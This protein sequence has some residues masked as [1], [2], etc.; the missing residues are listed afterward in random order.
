M[1]PAVS[2]MRPPLAVAGLEWL[3]PQ[4]P[5]LRGLG[6]S[7][8]DNWELSTAWSGLF[9]ATVLLVR[10]LYTRWGESN[11]TGKAIAL[12]L[13]IHMVGGLWTTTV[14]I[15][16][17]AA[18]VAK[19]E[20]IPI[21]RV[22]VESDRDR[23]PAKS[24]S[25][26]SW[27]RLP[28]SEREA[29][30]RLEK[31]LVDVPAAKLPERERSTAI[32]VA[33][34][35]PALV[36]AR[37]APTDPA[38]ARREDVKRP[39]PAGA[40]TSK[41]AEETADARAE[42][43]GSAVPGR[44]A[45]EN[46]GKP[47][48]EPSRMS[49]AP[50]ANSVAAN[51]R[52]PLVE[53]PRREDSPDAARRAGSDGGRPS[54]A[55]A[56]KPIPVAEGVGP[57]GTAAPS[58]GTA[59]GGMFSRGGP[60]RDTKRGAAGVDL[61][62]GR[63]GTVDG[64]QAPGLAVISSLPAG[65]AA[66]LPPAVREELAAVGA[67][68][69]VP[70]TYRL[71]GLPQRKKLAVEMGATEASELA[72]ERSLRWL[73]AHQSE[74]GFWDAD[75]FTRMCPPGKECGGL[76]GLGRDPTDASLDVPERQKSGIEADSGVTALSLLAFLGAGHTAVDGPYADTVD[77][78][79]RWLVRQQGT[80]G[81]LGGKAARYARMYCHGM[82]TIAL[83]EAYAMTGDATLREPL[84]RGVGF[85]LAAQLRDGGWRYDGA[86]TVGDMSLFGWQLMALRSAAMAG[87][88]VPLEHF[89]RAAGFLARNAQGN[90]GGLAA[91]GG[92]AQDTRVRPSMTAEAQY[93]RQ[94][95]GLANS[96]S[97]ASLE[98]M[99][100]LLQNAPNRQDYDL[101]YW[102]YGTLAV[103]H[104]GDRATWMAWNNTLR[105]TLVADQRKDGH[106]AGSWDPRAPWG[107]YGGRVFSTATS[108]LCLE[109]YYRFLPLYQTGKREGDV[110][111]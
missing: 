57:E 41:I 94:I 101:Y 26:P 63:Q 52:I 96:K 19:A 72:V 104:N 74:E 59:G 85:I 40:E 32:E 10:M 46:S 31:D 4:L 107:D 50:A 86:A 95:L 49:R 16:S 58:Q 68:S 91:Y 23:S 34:V 79:I 53:I 69:R 100:Y 90:A 62:S 87:V 99:S 29:I 35:S 51:E 61:R 60:L 88:A 109:V 37:P 55:L 17:G 22:V 84:E 13:L 38:A 42:A 75:G 24:K 7:V 83:G 45:R 102:Y 108:T 56:S 105:D 71:R 33:S 27:D 78:A 21:R 77:R 110:R 89:D 8:V 76:A 25:R 5:W 14:H 80:D 92:F 70:A 103:Y 18:A 20:R 15:A 66:A 54:A 9:V 97:P 82:A 39:D 73:A 30:S 65:S 36:G 67:G 81:F 11:V 106:A 111:R 93:S 28:E 48:A 1:I 64:S 98:A 2:E 43:G 44:A 47:T 12:S 6:T 3:E